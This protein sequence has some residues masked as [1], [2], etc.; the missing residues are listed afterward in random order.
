MSS[1]TH[2]ISI[3]IAFN[4][5][6]IKAINYFVYG[7]SCATQNFLSMLQEK[8]KFETIWMNPKLVR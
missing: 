4:A 3:L 7:K 8:L 5:Q 1:S 2:V 6:Q